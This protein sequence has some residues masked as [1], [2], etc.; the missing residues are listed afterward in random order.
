MQAV[1]FET[2]IKQSAIHIPLQFQYLDN[3]KAKV[4]LLYSEP[5]KQGNYNKQLLLLA[6]AQ[7][8]Q[9]GVFKSISNSVTW[10]RQLRND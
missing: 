1:E 10:Q 9:K 6:F 3:V 2:Y 7:A 4:I 5:E 8:Q